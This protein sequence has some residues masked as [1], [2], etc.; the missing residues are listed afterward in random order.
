M[1]KEQK[2]SE[3]MKGYVDDNENLIL[4]CRSLLLHLKD[5][6][7]KIICTNHLISSWS[8]YLLSNFIIRITKTIKN[9]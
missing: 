8:S 3:T 4:L 6:M 1:K 9:F 7:G 5:L 2:V